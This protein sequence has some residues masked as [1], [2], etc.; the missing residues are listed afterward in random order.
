MFWLKKQSDALQ[1]CEPALF[2]SLLYFRQVP[3]SPR[4]GTCS[5]AEASPVSV[6]RSPESP[7]AAA[8]G[9]GPQPALEPG[10]GRVGVRGDPTAENPSNFAAGPS[11]TPPPSVFTLV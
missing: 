8:G 6:L 1:T 11:C 10:G 4:L 2:A 3:R 7:G 9:E 5:R